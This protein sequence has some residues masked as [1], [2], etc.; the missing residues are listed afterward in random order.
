MGK[1]RSRKMTT[2]GPKVSIHLRKDEK[3]RESRKT[4]TNKKRLSENKMKVQKSDT[5][6]SKK[7]ECTGTRSQK[8]RENG[9]SP[10]SKSPVDSTNKKKGAKKHRKLCSDKKRRG[11]SAPWKK[12]APPA[13]TTSCPP[14]AWRCSTFGD[15]GLNC[16]VRNGTG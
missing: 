10:W 16:R 3:K 13:S 7:A 4:K 6:R 8:K 11:P 15:G 12:K 9:I 14:T 2:H 5:G 1:T